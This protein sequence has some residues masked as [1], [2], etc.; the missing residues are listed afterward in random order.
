MLQ[1]TAEQL[2]RVSERIFGAVGAPVEVASYMAE[3][4]VECDL[5]GHESHG[6]IRIPSYVERVENGRC[7]PAARPTILRETATTAVISGHWTFGQ[8]A[9]RFAAEQVIRKAKEAN[10]AAVAVVECNHQGRLGE[11]SAMIAQEGMIGM[12]VTGGFGAPFNPV[13]PYGGA[14]GVLGT[15]PYSFAVPAGTSAPFVADFA[16]SIIAE[17][18]LR[19]AQAKGI[20]VQE[21]ALIDAEGR[22]TT[23]PTAYQ[24]GGA[25]LAFG[26]HKGYALS[27]LADLLGSLLGGAEKVGTPPLTYGTFIMALRVDAFREFGEFGEAVDRRLAEVKAVPPAAGFKEVLIPGEPEARTRSLRLQQGIPVPEA[28]W[29]KIVEVARSHG[30]D[31]DALLAG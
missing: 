25:L 18:K 19:V 5:M 11:Y 15:N 27:L 30:V 7:D 16:T 2:R 24:K 8:V 21:G 3:T 31:V 23:D 14:K 12:V 1:F 6:I 26:G 4:L 9:A 17:G 22:P 10:V 13:A 28:T 29:E 20:A